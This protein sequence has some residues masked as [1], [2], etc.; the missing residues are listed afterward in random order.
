MTIAERFSRSWE[1]TKKTFSVLKKDKEI[2][3]FPV[4]SSLFSM[5]MFLLFIFP[6]FLSAAGERTAAAYV[7]VFGIYLVVAFSATFFNAGIVHIAKTRF[8]GKNATFMDGIKASIKHLP[9]I[10][11]WSLLSATVGVLLNVLEG[12]AREKRNILAR[13]AVSLV[14]A[15]WAIVS[16]FVVPAIVIK[17]YGPITALKSSAKAVKKTWGEALIKYYALGLAR[18][19]FIVAGVVVFLLPALAFGFGAG[20][21]GIALVLTGIFIT[22]FIVVMIVFSSANTIF[23]TAL[24]MY[25]DSGKVPSFYTREELSHAFGRRK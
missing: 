24:F 11:A 4:L 13:I 6:V 10:L 18:M 14:G 21:F 5:I 25:A 23:D 20:L 3:L 17:G 9:Q 22:Y 16:L 7:A 1:I 8:E 2:L 19:M 15:A 12:R